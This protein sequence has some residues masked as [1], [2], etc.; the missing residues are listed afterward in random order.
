MT[1]YLAFLR[2]INVAGHARVRM[3]DVRDT[4]VAAGCRK[5]RTYIQSGNVIFESPARDATVILQRIRRKLCAVLGEEPEILL[6][7]VREVERLVDESPFTQREAKSGAKL[8]VAFLPRRP[9][10]K[11]VFPLVS[12]KEAL[13]AVAM[14][15]REVFIVSRP[16]ENGFFGF[17][18]NFIEKELGVSATSRNWSTVTKIVEFARRGA[19]R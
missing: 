12:S 3:T 8:Y 9:R 6:R 7:T 10:R 11:P 18:N 2:A 15:D 17:P 1:H 13:E 16:K 19:D 14:S 5:V 4:F